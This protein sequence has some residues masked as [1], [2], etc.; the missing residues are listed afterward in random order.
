MSHMLKRC[1]HHEYF[2]QGV[3]NT[4][5]YSAGPFAAEAPW[6]EPLLP[7]S[8]RYCGNETLLEEMARRPKSR[9]RGRGESRLT[10]DLCV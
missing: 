6:L 2:A 3:T 10:S 9:F 8:D 1:T 5:G 7:N 4:S